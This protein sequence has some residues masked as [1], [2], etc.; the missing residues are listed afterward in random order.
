MASKTKKDFGRFKKERRWINEELKIFATVL[1]GKEDFLVK[2]ET[3]ALKK[4]SVNELF[5]NIKVKF[6]EILENE[7]LKINLERG[8]KFKKC[9]KIDSSVLVNDSRV[10]SR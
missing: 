9:P 2:L 5:K 8:M 3:K 4:L 6:D 1:A 10:H 7:R